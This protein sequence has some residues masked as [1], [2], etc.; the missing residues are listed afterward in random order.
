M[1]ASVEGNKFRT[2]K[3]FQRD[4]DGSLV[5]FSLF[6]FLA[7]L[8][9]GGIAVDLML[10]ENR[11]THIQNS[12]DRAVLA[13]ANLNQTVDPTEVVQDYLAKVGVEVSEE[14]VTVVEIGEAPVITGRQVS[15]SVNSNGDTILMNLVGVDTLPYGASSEAEEGVNDVEVSLVLDISGSMRG[16][17]LTQ[18]Q[19][20]AKDFV[21]GIL[22]GAS[23]NRV[24]VSLIPYA[25]QVSAGPDLLSRINTCLLY[26]SPSPRD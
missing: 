13:A 24:S 4:E 5:M 16:T 8:M 25:A 19:D 1:Y 11:R 14:D 7:M 3:K 9:F 20:A 12:T 10:Y 22:E 18:M 26:T 2:L 6:I 17:K 15:V 21:D 23:D